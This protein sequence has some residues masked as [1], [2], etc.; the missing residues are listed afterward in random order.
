MR[1]HPDVPPDEW[2]QVASWIAGLGETRKALGKNATFAISPAQLLG[3]N[4]TKARQNVAR[5]T[6]RSEPKIVYAKDCEEAV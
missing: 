5:E 2:L 3:E 6:P 1:Q 4:I